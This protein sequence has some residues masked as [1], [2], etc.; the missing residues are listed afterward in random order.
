[1]ILLETAGSR[2]RHVVVLFGAGLIGSAILRALRSARPMS[3]DHLPVRWTDPQGFSSDLAS[4]ETILRKRRTDEKTPLFTVVCSAGRARFEASAEETAPELARF[5]DV[6]AFAE[7]IASGPA[8]GRV[9]FVLISSAGGLYEGQRIVTRASRPEPRRMYAHLK[10]EQQ[11]LLLDKAPAL[12]ST[13]LLPSSVYGFARDGQRSGLVSTMI[14][15]GLRQMVTTISG[16]LST[17]RDFVWA[18]DIGRFAANQILHGTGVAGS[19]MIL[20]SARPTSIFEVQNMAQETLGRKIF[21]AFS[22]E[23]T[24]HDD[25]TFAPSVL[26]L[27]WSASDLHTNIRRVFRDALGTPPGAA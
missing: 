13:I 6:L 27:G 11:W 19:A 25:I 5:S 20:A 3:A 24:N 10:L 7:R 26:P 17:L 14:V 4:A 12:H 8:G 15:N 23:A 22:P 9:Q 18:D 2:P 16:S 21:L 1:V